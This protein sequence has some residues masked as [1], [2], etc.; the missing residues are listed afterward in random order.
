MPALDIQALQKHITSRKLGP[1]YVLVGEDAK[2]IERFVDGIESTIDEADRPFAVDRLYATL[3][4]DDNGATPIDIVASANGLPMLGD[5]RIVIVLRAER[6]LKPRRGSKA[7]ADDEDADAADA[8]DAATVDVAPLEAYVVDPN[9]TTTLVFVA[10]DIDKARRLTKK[11]MENAAVVECR[12]FGGDGKA[13]QREAR[14]IAS[15][16]LKDEL[17]RAGKGIDPDALQLLVDRSG[18]D[19]TKLRGDVERLM[20]YTEGRKKIASDDVLEA[21]SVQV[22]VDDWAVVNALGDGDAARA[23]RAAGDRLDRGDSPHALVGQLRWWVSAH[24]GATGDMPRVR[25]S[26]DALL[27]TDVALKSSGGDDR[28]LI[29]RLIV[30]LTGKPVPRPYG[31]R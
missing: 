2:L 24:I 31:R 7:A 23:L 21:V 8:G 1:V 17:T 22:A 30:E 29:E 12:G 4:A 18:N 10:T 5:R 19:I 15:Q 26:I 3:Y 14:G 28:V 25:K 20:L 16:W 9:P 11:V 6:L 13:S 27:R